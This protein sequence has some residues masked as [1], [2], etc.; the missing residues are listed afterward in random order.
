MIE[1]FFTISQS[2]T[3]VYKEKGSKFLA[4]AHPVIDSEQIK[5]KLIDL[6]R[7]FYDANHHCYAWILGP[8]K[9]QFKVFDDGEPNHSAGDPILNQIK[10]KNLTNILVVVVRY[11]GGVKLGV[12]GLSA[13]YK[14]ATQATLENAS[15]IE[16]TIT[17]SIS[18]HYGYP[19]TSI[20][21]K[22]MSDFRLKPVEEK[23]G[24]T[25]SLKCEVRLRDEEKLR[26][27]I[28]TLEKQGFNIRL[29]LQR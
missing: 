15:I 18:I 25:C 2:S 3:G 8:D 27:K 9:S 10:S 6:K 19:E 24:E 29:D 26:V 17:K 14:L 7:E 23:F 20:V 1:S 12:S 21:K 16:V 4:F 5:G 22:L 11:F 28:E 13:A